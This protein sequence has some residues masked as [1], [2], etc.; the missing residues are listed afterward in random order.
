[1]NSRNSRSVAS[2]LPEELPIVVSRPA[3]EAM[4][5]ACGQAL[6]LEASGFLLGV[7]RGRERHATDIVLAQGGAAQPGGF[8]IADHELRRLKAWAE[9]RG[10]DILALFHSHPSGSLS[11]SAADRAALRYSEWPWLVVAHRPG[12]ALALALYGQGST[13]RMPPGFVRLGQLSL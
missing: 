5:A 8:D 4:E 13:R 2:R 9:D 3:A 6:P 11:L 1:M 10:L 12:R 7:R